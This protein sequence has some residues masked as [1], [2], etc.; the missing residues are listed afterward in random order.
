MATT[1]SHYTKYL[2]LMSQAGL[3]HT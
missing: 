1:L 2:S 3:Y